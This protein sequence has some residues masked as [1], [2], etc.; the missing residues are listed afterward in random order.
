MEEEKEGVEEETPGKSPNP[1][2][3]TIPYSR[4]KEVN[5]KRKE[6]E[7]QVNTLKASGAPK[8]EVQ[9]AEKKAEEYLE[10]LTDK[11]LARREQAKAEAERVEQDQFNQELDDILIANPSVKRSEFVKFTEENMGKYGISSLEGALSLY[12]DFGDISKKA[13]EE[14]EESLEK[15]P[16]LPKNE[17]LGKQGNELPDDSNKTF[18]QVLDEVVRGI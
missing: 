2:E 12:K 13:K 6:L 16:G 14:I 10:K 5:D 4:F 8:E 7:E 1:E 17:G 15:K 18:N 11:V 3:Q 9:D